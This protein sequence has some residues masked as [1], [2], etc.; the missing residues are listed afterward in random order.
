M[1]ALIGGFIAAMLFLETEF[2]LLPGLVGGFAL[3]GLY[4]L[5]SP[6]WRGRGVAG[7]QQADLL[8]SAAIALSGDAMALVEDG[9]KTVEANAAYCE[10]SRNEAASPPSPERFLALMPGT[11]SAMSDLLASIAAGQ[12]LTRTIRFDSGMGGRRMQISVQPLGS[13]RRVLWALRLTGGDVQSVPAAAASTGARIASGI[14]ARGAEK[15][16]EAEL[17]EKVALVPVSLA[18]ASEVTPAQQAVSLTRPSGEPSL[19]PNP[20]LEVWERA[21]AGVARF[22]AEQ[23][24]LANVGL[25]RILGYGLAE[26]G[27]AGLPLRDVV[28]S[29]DLGRLNA[30]LTP[31]NKPANLQ[32]VL[33]RKDGSALPVYMRLGLVDQAGTATGVVLPRSVL[34]AGEGVSGEVR[35]VEVSAPA[36]PVTLP[37]QAAAAL[38]E[39]GKSVQGEDHFFMRAPLA[40]AIV[41]AG[42][43]LRAA[44][45]A[46]TRL[47]GPVAA[48]E[49]IPL[50]KAVTEQDGA[51]VE[52]LLSEARTRKTD[53]ET[54]MLVCEVSTAQGGRAVRLYAAPLTQDGEVA[55]CAIEASEQKAREAQIAQSQRLQ[56]VGHLAGGVAH[57]FN[58]VLT[59]IIGYCDLLLTKHRPSDPSFPDIMQIR[60]NANR[61][62]ALV[63]QLLA[64]SRRQTLRPQVI[65]L[66]DV[67]SDVSELLRRLIGERI[68]LEVHHA[69]DL[70]PVKVDVNQ[71]EQV[72]VNLV[73]NARDAM[74]DGGTLTLRTSNVLASACAT[75]GEALT[76]GDYVLVEV[77]DTGTGIP[78]D[79]IDKIFEPFFSTKE[80][81]KGTG[82]G[83]STVYGI[84]QQTGGT[85]LA[86]SEPGQGT[87]F[88][89]FLPRHV[90][91]AEEETPRT[92]EPEV[93]VGDSTGQ[94]RILLVEDE[95][96]VRAFASRALAARGYEVVTA[97]CGVEALE[98]MQNL[99]QPVNLVISDVV[100]PE[101]DGPTLLRELRAKDPS[102]KVIFMSGYAEEAFSRN[103][104]PDEHFSFLPKPFSLKQL[105]AAVNTAMRGE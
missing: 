1:P 95:D 65:E 18:P 35:S 72:I 6:L 59:A 87:T 54:A 47:F 13:P 60:Q 16:I 85:I 83:L 69:R 84:V 71:F 62:A 82:L 14:E 79:V 77:E 21:P 105:V 86:V 10:L 29:E 45:A 26:W 58:N 78:P 99:E 90:P 41:D 64:F 103:L 48:Q 36:A 17:P 92:P 88:Q 43:A 7:P 44:N 67:I 33:M 68:T 61:A 20:L 55:L 25:C 42:G 81:G 30:A 19:E 75:Y 22:S 91:T 50:L 2:W 37:V 89:V 32:L 27:S 28:S 3:F 80:V 12:A 53:A 46:F 104:P 102:L 63:R 8:G 73:V 11:Q 52:S 15:P 74:P 96:A 9:E 5:V 51:G 57:D 66:T 93:K 98:V 23:V 97:A 49:G 4:A 101:M 34:P 94:G 38:V 39:T 24:Q 100:M 31:G 76:A 70:W 56:A 40:L